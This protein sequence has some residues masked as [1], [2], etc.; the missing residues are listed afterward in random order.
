MSVELSN[1]TIDTASARNALAEL[2]SC[3]VELQ[4]FISDVFDRIDGLAGE[5][6]TREIACQQARYQAERETVQTQIETLSSVAAELTK[7]LAEEKDLFERQN[8]ALR[9]RSP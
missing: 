1:E 3:Q 2:K 4:E 5:L 8:Q 6:L 7:A 9:K